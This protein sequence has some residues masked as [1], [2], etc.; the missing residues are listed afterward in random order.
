MPFRFSLEEVL[1]YRRRMEEI[2]QRELHEA[3]SRMEYVQG[4]VDEAKARRFHYREELEQLVASRKPAAYRTLYM[5]YLRGVDAL[6]AKSELHVQDLEKE[7]RRRL[8]FL[9]YAVRQRQVL[10]E[11]K[12]EEY[13]LYLV[14]ERRAETREFDEIAIRNFSVN[15]QEKNAQLQEGNA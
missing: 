13:K 12:K 9:E 8:T 2:R 3:R 5:D 11:L 6:I 14:E 10:D 7:V 1:D 4:L 15:Q